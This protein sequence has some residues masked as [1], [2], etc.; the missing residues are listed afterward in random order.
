M[1]QSKIYWKIRVNNI[2]GDSSLV[3][4][5]Y[6][7][8]VSLI[9][10]EQ[11]WVTYREGRNNAINLIKC[12]SNVD[13]KECGAYITVRKKQINK[14]FFELSKMINDHHLAGCQSE[15]ELVETEQFINN[16][17]IKSLLS[18]IEKK[19]KKYVQVKI[20]N[21]F[22]TEVPEK[23]GNPENEEIVKVKRK[24]QLVDIKKTLDYIFERKLDDKYG[25]K[26]SE[27]DEKVWTN[28]FSNKCTKYLNLS[29]P[30]KSENKILKWNWKKI[31][32]IQT[33]LNG[34]NYVSICCKNFFYKGTKFPEKANIG[35]TE[36]WVKIKIS[37]EIKEKINKIK[38]KY[39]KEINFSLLTGC[40]LTT[41]LLFEKELNSSN[42]LK[43]KIS[44]IE[45]LS[46]WLICFYFENNYKLL[47]DIII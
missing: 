14:D 38:N 26:V 44:P 12:A 3:Y 1:E 19:D 10:Q 18:L 41:N 36:I 13:G 34:N 28:S 39:G 37:N 17:S 22:F 6:Y 20:K 21:S 32:E 40:E 33:D 24:K 5:N 42:I 46:D 31:P 7:E 25:N 35:N 2:N 47:N 16:I 23:S 43:L 4:D 11:I 9:E 8:N 30:K 15:A 27:F 45:C 29:P